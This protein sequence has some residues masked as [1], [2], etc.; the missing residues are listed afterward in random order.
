MSIN[1]V[2]V[3]TDRNDSKNKIAFGNFNPVLPMMDAINRGGFAASFISQDMLGMAIPRTATG[4]TRNTGD[5]GET[6]TAYAKLVAIREFLSGP[7]T[8][9]IPLLMIWGIKKHFGRANN[10]PVSFIQGF[11]NDFTNFAQVN[12]ELLGKSTELKHAYYKHAVEN[13]INASTEGM[14]E[15]LQKSEAEKLT[16]LLIEMEK[17]PKKPFYTKKSANGEGVKYGKTL[18]G[19]FIE[20]FVQYRKQYSTNPSNKVFKAWFNPGIKI[21]NESDGLSTNVSTFIDNLMD[22]TDDVTKSIG[23]KF[24]P[25][26]GDIKKFI[27]EFCHKRVGSRVI[28]NASMT[29]AV[30]LFFT[31]IPKLYNR[32]DGK[33]PALAGLAN[34]VKPNAKKSEGK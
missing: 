28:A 12:P 29:V 13:L 33:N 8:F 32:K 26:G 31:I 4:L 18:R 25:E 10:V 17:A 2:S 22:Y 24:K 6:N 3:N 7:S 1:P 19:E 34:D 11:S 27:E 20:E 14:P 16:N 5:T 21:H 23:K 15:S 30:G 9:A